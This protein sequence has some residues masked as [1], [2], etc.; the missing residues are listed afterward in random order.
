MLGRKQTQAA[1]VSNGWKTDVRLS[2]ARAAS[3]LQ[4]R[5]LGDMS[6]RML[7]LVLASLIVK[8]RRWATMSAS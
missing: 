6:M 1:N 5:M 3:K 4:S 8:A 7:L 2:A